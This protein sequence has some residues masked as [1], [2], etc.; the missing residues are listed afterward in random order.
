MALEKDWSYSWGSAST[1]WDSV[2]LRWLST[3]H[4]LLWLLSPASWAT[5]QLLRHPLFP[6]TL[7]CSSHCSSLSFI[8]LARRISAH[9]SRINPTLTMKSLQPMRSQWKPVFNSQHIPWVME[10]SKSAQLDLP[11]W[12]CS[13]PWGPSLQCHLY[14]TVEMASAPSREC[15]W[16]YSL[17]T[18]Q[19]KIHGQIQFLCLNHQSPVCE[20]PGGTFNNKL[21]AWIQRT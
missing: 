18:F 8:F 7:L 10:L 11:P 12:T 19:K 20:H 14:T 15:L 2:W 21:K 6:W 16:S 1:A 13:P 4:S 3:D 17:F 5:D 9:P